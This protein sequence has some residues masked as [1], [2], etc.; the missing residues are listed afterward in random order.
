MG[1]NKGIK[2]IQ[3]APE[4]KSIVPALVLDAKIGQFF[5]SQNLVHTICEFMRWPS[6][7][8]QRFPLD[9]DPNMP[10][11]MNRDWKA[12]NDYV[13]GMR[14]I[15]TGSVSGEQ[16]FVASGISSFAM[17]GAEEEDFRGQMIRTADR[18]PQLNAREHHFHWPMVLVRGR[19]PNGTFIEKR[20]PMDLLMVAP[21]QRVPKNK[22]VED[23]P[24]AG[25]PQ[26]RFRDI[27][28]LMQQLDLDQGGSRNYFLQA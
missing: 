12:V 13:R 1:A 19:G 17:D 9:R 15:F 25:P 24:R 18:F 14:L 28:S 5:K 22:Q 10:S 26:T 2:F 4:S 11:R 7:R 20:Y 8:Y 3:A 27:H 16:S 23:P 21:Y 6:D